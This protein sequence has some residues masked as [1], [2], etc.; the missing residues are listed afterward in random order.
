MSSSMLYL[1]DVP[2]H[3]TKKKKKKRWRPI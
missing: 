2:F 3:N 1:D